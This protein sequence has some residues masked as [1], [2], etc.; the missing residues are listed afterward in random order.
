MKRKQLIRGLF[1]ALAIA[2]LLATVLLAYRFDKPAP[3]PE[4]VKVIVTPTATP[5]PTKPKQYE[6]HIITLVNKERAKHGLDPVIELATLDGSAHLKAQ[7][8]NDH[9]E[10]WSHTDSKGRHFTGFITDA[11]WKG[12]AAENLAKGYATDEETV[13]A[14]MNSPEHRVNVLQPN[15]IYAGY[16]QVG[17]YRVMHFGGY[18]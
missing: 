7:D 12:T 15:A 8:L 11:G 3:K 4:P 9:Q 17:N 18:H 1:F 10:N 6:Q 13:T 16:S 5:A 14:W 2:P